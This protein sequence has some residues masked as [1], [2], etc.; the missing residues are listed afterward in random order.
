MIKGQLLKGSFR[1]VSFDF[2]DTSKT[3]G[4][5]SVIHTF[6]NSDT[7]VSEDLGRQALVIGMRIIVGGIGQ[8]YYSQRDAVEGALEKKG[9]GDLVHPTRGNLLVQLSGS[10]SM[11]ESITE[12]GNT[13]FDVTFTIVDK[14]QFLPANT[15]APTYVTGKTKVIN[16]K[17]AKKVDESMSA[18]AKAGYAYIK[19][20]TDKL[21]KDI[22]DFA[23]PVIKNANDLNGVSKLGKSIASDVGGAVASG[24]GTA[25]NSLLTDVGLSIDNPVDSFSF[26]SG[27]FDFGDDDPIVEPTTTQLAE[28]SQNQDSVRTLVQSEALTLSVN[29]ATQIEY[30]TDEELE[31]VA[32]QVYVQ[33]DKVVQLPLI[34]SDTF[35]LLQEQRVSFTKFVEDQ[36]LQVLKVTTVTV[37]NQSLTTLAYIYYGNQDNVDLLKDLNNFENPSLING[38]VKIATS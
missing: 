11:T 24:Y 37:I 2:L 7:V 16:E 13:T 22:K 30:K 14:K 32:Q 35:S 18:L 19:A 29:S 1:G 34:D 15:A 8:A 10:Y 17:V 12:L 28:V 6:P 9:T 25:I 20:K 33:Y 5:K 27:L 21:V 36:T 26:F 38:S 4:R 3:S 31:A 23:A